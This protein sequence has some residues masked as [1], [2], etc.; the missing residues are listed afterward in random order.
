MTQQSTQPKP[1]DKMPDGTIYAGISPDTGK[2]MYA[3]PADAPLRMKFN[4]AKEYAASLEAHGHQ[5]WRVPTKAELNV[6]F[7]NRAAI[8]GF[9]VSGAPRVGW[10]LSDTPDFGWGAWC[11]R[12]SSGAQCRDDVDEGNPASVRLVR[13]AAPKVT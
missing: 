6:L 10:Y 1:G 12:F 9:N 11:Q 4:E 2:I 7:N 3:T 5:D 8:G 13:S